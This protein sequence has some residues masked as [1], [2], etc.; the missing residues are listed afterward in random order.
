M[1]LLLLLFSKFNG[2]QEW[3]AGVK[4]CAYK[5][6][7]ELLSDWMSA[8]RSVPASPPVSAGWD[9]KHKLGPAEVSRHRGQG[10]FQGRER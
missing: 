6:V 2:F 3:Q 7:E 4:L 5:V 1:F 8:G 9:V 10:G